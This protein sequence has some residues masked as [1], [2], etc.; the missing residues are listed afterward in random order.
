[1][2]NLVV[3]LAAFATVTLACMATSGLL[4][5]IKRED[6]REVLAMAKALWLRLPGRGGT[7]GADDTN[8]G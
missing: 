8:A 7:G 3:T 1:M 5:A 6:L 2:S 4:G